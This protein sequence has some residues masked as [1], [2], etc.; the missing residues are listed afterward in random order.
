[1]AT[2]DAV[3]VMLHGL[4][5]RPWKPI[6]GPELPG[7]Q[8]VVVIPQQHAAGGLSGRIAACVSWLRWP[9]KRGFRLRTRRDLVARGMNCMRINCSYDGPEEWVAAKHPKRANREVGKQCRRVSM[10]LAGPK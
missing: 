8:R 4:A 5:G 7:G 3:L 2:I 6:R 1:M 10:D 9:P